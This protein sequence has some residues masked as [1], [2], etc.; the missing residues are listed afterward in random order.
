MVSIC[1]IIL[2]IIV[3]F[4]LLASR[5]ITSIRTRLSSYTKPEVILTPSNTAEML[6]LQERY[7]SGDVLYSRHIDRRQTYQVKMH[8]YEVDKAKSK[9]AGKYL[10]CLI[11]SKQLLKDSTQHWMP[12]ARNRIGTLARRIRRQRRLEQSE[13]I[14]S[15]PLLSPQFTRRTA[16]LLLARKVRK[17]D[18][19]V[20]YGVACHHPSCRRRRGHRLHS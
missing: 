14:F 6:A 3:L 5:A 20:D 15:L 4:K 9:P 12:E 10:C 2:S 17:K 11:N 7:P 1:I 8:K 16:S 13:L 18:D 19:A